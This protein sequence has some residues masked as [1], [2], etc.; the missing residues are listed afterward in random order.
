MMTMRRTMMTR[1]SKPETTPADT[2]GDPELNP[3]VDISMGIT[4]PGPQEYSSIRCD[5][6]FSNINVAH[7]IEPQIQRCVEV[8]RQVADAG[9]APQLAEQV[10]NAS[11]F[12]VEGL[13]L[14]KAFED[15]KDRMT[16]WASKINKHVDFDP[17]K[18]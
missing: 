13:G 17:R 16:K 11:G 2:N 18:E 12:S 9:V 6:R 1:R 8:A 15:F 5:V 3:L 4:I 7:D 10:A 14:N